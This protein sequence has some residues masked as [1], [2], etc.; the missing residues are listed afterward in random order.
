MA[1]PTLCIVS[2]F[3]T[4]VEDASQTFVGV[5]H[6]D[7]TRCEGL[8]VFLHEQLTNFP[9]VVIAHVFARVQSGYD[10]GRFVEGV[11][12]NA[13]AVSADFVEDEAF[14]GHAL[15]TDADIGASQSTIFKHVGERVEIARIENPAASRVGDAVGS[16]SYRATIDRGQIG[17][18]VRSFSQDTTVNRGGSSKARC[19]FPIKEQLRAVIAC[20]TAHTQWECLF[21]RHLVHESAGVVWNEHRMQMTDGE[22][23]KIEILGI[24]HTRVIP[25]HVFIEEL[26]TQ[27]VSL[28]EQ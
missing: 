16:S 8:R 5:Q 14:G 10:S 15:R 11:V 24:P 2:I 7:Q 6:E 19:Q 25:E 22:S 1:P 27:L 20:S 9:S 3:R 13:W 17:N 18:R 21:V 12:G 28:M 4:V 26:P 23:K